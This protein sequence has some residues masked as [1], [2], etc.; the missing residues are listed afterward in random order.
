MQAGLVVGEG[1]EDGFEGVEF[2]RGIAFRG[3]GL[4]EARGK[5]FCS[6]LLDVRMYDVGC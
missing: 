4:S 6:R 3:E 1:F 2:K 5:F